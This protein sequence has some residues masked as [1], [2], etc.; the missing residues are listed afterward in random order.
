MTLAIV[1]V[2]PEPVTPIKVWNFLPAC[3]LS[4]SRSI[5]CGWSPAG[6]NSLFSLNFAIFGSRFVIRGSCLNTLF[7]SIHRFILRLNMAKFKGK[8][9]RGFGLTET[10]RDTL[11]TLGIFVIKV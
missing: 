3:R 4:T 5:A 6:L 7:M 1:K 9:R 2:L 8:K 10:L 11:F